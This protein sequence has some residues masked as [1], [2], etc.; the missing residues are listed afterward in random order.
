MIMPGVCH[1]KAAS[2]AA[3]ANG[4][5]RIVLGCPQSPGIDVLT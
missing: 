1:P 5:N 3:A 4:G 2:T